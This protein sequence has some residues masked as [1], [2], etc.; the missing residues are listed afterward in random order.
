MKYNKLL[1]ATDD[2]FP[3]VYKA[4]DILLLRNITAVAR[5]H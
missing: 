4:D 1:V 5:L 2:S 3:S